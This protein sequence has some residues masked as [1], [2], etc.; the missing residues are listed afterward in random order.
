MCLTQARYGIA[1]GGLGAAMDCY[2][3][4][5]EYAKERIQFNGQPIAGHQLVQEKL[6]WMITEITKGQLLACS[7]AASRTPARSTTARLDGQ[8]Q[9]RLGGARV[10]RELAREILGANGIVDDYPVIRHM[11]NIESVYTYEGTHDIHG[12]MIGEAVTGIPAYKPPRRE[13]EGRAQP[14]GAG[15]WAVS[16]DASPRAGL[17]PRHRAGRD[18]RRQ[19]HGQGD[20]EGSD[21]GGGRGDAARARHAADRRPHR[22]R[23]GRARQ[24]ADALHRRGGGQRSR[25]PRTASGRHRGRPA[26]GHQPLR[27]RDAGR[28][29]GARRLRARR[30]AARPRRLHGQDH[31]RPTARGHVHIDAPVA[32][33]LRNIADAFGREVERPDVV[34]LDRPRHEQLIADIREAGARIR[35]I[36][37]GDLSAAI[38][39]RC[40]AP[41]CTR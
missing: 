14:V 17:H 41:A 20:R 12:L 23:R 35:L 4:A 37:D 40:A 39:A 22:H 10:A 2:T 8:A 13:R 38:S 11:M 19:D 25:A 16:L 28:D 9:Q 21:R 34:V 33:N 26:R 36:G 32:E 1:W 7:S 3:T 29:R 31:R 27:H 6:A 15:R 24:G 5:L 18:R 30:P